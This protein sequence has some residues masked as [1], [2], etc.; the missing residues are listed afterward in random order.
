MQ[1]YDRPLRRAEDDKGYAVA[2]QVLLVG[3]TREDILSVF[4]GFF[5]QMRCS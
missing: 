3:N 5:L 2:G 4:K 1:F